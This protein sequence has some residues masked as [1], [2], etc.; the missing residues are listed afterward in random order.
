MNIIIY[1]KR[2]NKA[3]VVNLQSHRHGSEKNLS[4]RE[5]KYI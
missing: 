4:E 3:L 5:A 1:L 2:M